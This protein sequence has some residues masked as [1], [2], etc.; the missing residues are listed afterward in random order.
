MSGALAT[1]ATEDDCWRR[2]GINGD[3]SC[4]ELE[5]HI[6]CRS[7][8]VYGKAA[9]TFFDRPAPEGYRAEWTKLLSHEKQVVESDS[10]S[11]LLFRLAGEWLALRTNVL[12]EVTHPRPV[13]RIP[14][15]SHDSLLGLVNIRGQ[16]QLCVSLHGLLGVAALEGNEAESLAADE[17]GKMVHPRLVV[18]ERKTQRWAF[19]ADDVR[20]V[21]RI[22]RTQ[23]QSVP[24]TLTRVSSFSQAVFPWRN[25]TVGF[26][27]DDRVLSA[28]RSVGL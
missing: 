21:G 23:F 13:H 27:D 5:T 17:I 16:L 7:C 15:K 9:R 6:H 25:H 19:P 28:F 24:S 14:H 10:V 11:V 12:S 18:I 1:L 26:L 4:P 20:G 3:R 22:A 2:I 8:P